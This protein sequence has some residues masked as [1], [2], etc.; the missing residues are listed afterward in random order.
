MKQIFN[1]SDF[2]Y[3][4]EDMKLAFRHAYSLGKSDKKFNMDEAAEVWM[5]IYRKE[6]P[7]PRP[8]DVSYAVLTFKNI[9]KFDFF[10]KSREH[11]L[12][13]ARDLMSWFCYTYCKETMQEIADYMKYPSHAS[14]HCGF[15][16][17]N[18][19][20]KIYKKVREEAD[21]LKIMLLSNGFRLQIQD[22]V[23]FFRGDIDKKEQITV[24]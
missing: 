4:A 3:T 15:N 11:P 12:P 7:L 1:T 19:E 17:I 21:Q 14:I 22:R 20:M 10:G 24:K 8:H 13:H 9:D 18:T 2:L 16:N 23:L 5:A 6:M